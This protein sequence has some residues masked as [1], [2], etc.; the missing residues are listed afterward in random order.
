MK[1]AARAKSHARRPLSDF[2]IYCQTL[3][4]VHNCYSFFIKKTSLKSR[5]PL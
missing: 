4:F 1:A 5:I 2:I 3:L